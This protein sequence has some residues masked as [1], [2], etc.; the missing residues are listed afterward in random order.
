MCFADYSADEYH[1]DKE[2][3]RKPVLAKGLKS[4]ESSIGF[5]GTLHLPEGNLALNEYVCESVKSRDH[6]EQNN[7]NDRPPNDLA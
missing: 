7:I 5:I 1:P 6:H 2:V 4:K 3:D